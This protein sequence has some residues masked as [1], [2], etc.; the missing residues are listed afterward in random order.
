MENSIA[1]DGIYF[2]NIEEYKIDIDQVIINII[3]KGHRLVFA[4]VV[5]YTDINEFVIRKYP[6]LR[7]YILNRI[8]YYKEIQ[9][10]NEKIDR[11][12]KSL[13]GRNKNI[14]VI[15]LMNKCKFSSESIYENPY[16]KEKIR[17]VVVENSHR[18][19][20]KK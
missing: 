16:L 5:K 13:I 19:I 12:V 15:A 2:K 17:A 11:A 1:N 9:V 18:F 6:E 8:S 20:K 3:S 14:T 7:V 10:I 4:N